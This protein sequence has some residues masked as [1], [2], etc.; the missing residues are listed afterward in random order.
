MAMCSRRRC[1]IV[2]VALLLATV[3]P[4]VLLLQL[5]VSAPAS[6]NDL[7]PVARLRT[8]GSDLLFRLR[9][10]TAPW[11]RCRFVSAPIVYLG[12]G[13]D[14]DGVT[15]DESTLPLWHLTLAAETA[16]CRTTPTL[17]VARVWSVGR[18]A[19]NGP[20]RTAFDAAASVVE[21]AAPFPTAMVPTLASV[22]IRVPRDNDTRPAWWCVQLVL[23][24]DASP[25]DQAALPVELT[26]TKP[27]LLRLD[28]W[29]PHS[30]FESFLAAVVGDS[31]S[32][33]STFRQLLSLLVYPLP[34]R[35]HAVRGEPGITRSRYDFGTVSMLVHLGDA[36]QDPQSSREAF[37]YW[38]APLD[39]W[40]TERAFAVPVLALAGNHDSPSRWLVHSGMTPADTAARRGTYRLVRVN[41]NV[42]FIVLD[43]NAESEEQVEWLQS[44]CVR[45]LSVP[46]ARRPLLVALSHVPPFVEYWDPIAWHQRNESAWPAY[47]RERLLPLLR[48]CDVV[49]LLS[50]HSH[51]YQFGEDPGG[52]GM[53]LIV[54]GGGGGALE[55]AVH[56]HVL[57]PG[58]AS[59]YNTTIAAHHVGLLYQPI[60]HRDLTWWV[61]DVH[62]A[63]LDSP[64][65]MRPQ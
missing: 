4:V 65:L 35:Q 37:M 62:G 28:A 51:I 44:V 47:M 34:R 21:F 14:T 7:L 1:L 41:H 15:D 39:D 50:G 16:S 54:C 17:V 9:E 36:M 5:L 38:T 55:H 22:A 10:A 8:I 42:S 40:A 59:A 6:S 2:C 52:S 26:A 61:S 31:Q 57:A 23:L 53:R 25:N 13:P 3:I 56:D 19:G 24:R 60:V 33:V 18:S 63:R 32:G 30:M 45:R 12:S 43:T 48:R 20:A 11:F 29:Q 46:L 64:S 27:L 58:A 49:A